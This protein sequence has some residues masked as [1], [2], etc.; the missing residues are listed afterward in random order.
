[1]HANHYTYD[2][3]QAVV[4]NTGDFADI[5]ITIVHNLGAGTADL[6]VVIEHLVEAD[7]GGKSV[8]QVD[9]NTITITLKD[10]PPVTGVIKGFVRRIHSEV[11]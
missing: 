11:R 7:V 1:M 9:L 8:A 2:F 10:Y 6:D 5:V 4:N 3:N